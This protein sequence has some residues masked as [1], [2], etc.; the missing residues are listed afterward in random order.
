MR[1]SNECN[2]MY[3]LDILVLFAS[4]GFVVSSLMVCNLFFLNQVVRSLVVCVL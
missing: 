3:L 4:L 2:W 1:V